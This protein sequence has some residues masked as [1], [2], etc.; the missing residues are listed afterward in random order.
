MKKYGLEFKKKAYRGVA[1]ILP[2][3][4]FDYYE[5]EDV[6]KALRKASGGK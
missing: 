1:N 6:V 2:Y 3:D 5:E 4:D